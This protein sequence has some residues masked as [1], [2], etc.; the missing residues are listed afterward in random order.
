MQDAQDFVKEAKSLIARHTIN[1]GAIG[2]LD[3]LKIVG[4]EVVTDELVD[5][6]KGFADTV[7]GEE[8]LQLGR[9]L[10]E[11]L[12]HP[13]GGEAGGLGLGSLGGSIRPALDEA[14]GIPDLVA[15]VAPLLAERLI[16]ENVVPCRGTHDEPHTDTISTVLIY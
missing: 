5:E 8:I 12:A 6:G 15:E 10:A 3:E 2:R 14:E 16:E 7:L 11:H 4:G 1:R 13:V 9:S